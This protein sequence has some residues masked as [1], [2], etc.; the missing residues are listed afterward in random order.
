MIPA[1][2]SLQLKKTAK[3]RLIYLILNSKMYSNSNIR[4][5]YSE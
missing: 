4:G 3:K 2:I 5:G 1:I